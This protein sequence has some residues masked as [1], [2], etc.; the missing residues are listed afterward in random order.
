MKVKEVVAQIAR[1]ELHQR[2]CRVWDQVLETTDK[3]QTEVLVGQITLVADELLKHVREMGAKHAVDT[4]ACCTRN[5]RGEKL[6]PANRVKEVQDA[7]WRQVER[8]MP[9]FW[10]IVFAH[11]AKEAN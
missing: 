9:N 5:I 6:A 11:R 1:S 7:F 10:Q 8:Q 3:R 2:F 4:L